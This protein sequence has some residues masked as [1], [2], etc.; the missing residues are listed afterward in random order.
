[1]D[2]LF[3]SVDGANCLLLFPTVVLQQ[4]VRNFSR[5]RLGS[6]FEL[7]CLKSSASGNKFTLSFRQ[8]VAVYC[9]VKFHDVAYVDKT[10]CDVH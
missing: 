4:E 3:I 7:F 2:L 10:Y 9:V 6:L 5:S 1:V 8:P